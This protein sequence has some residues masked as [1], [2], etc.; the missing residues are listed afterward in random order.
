[1]VSLW[2]RRSLA[3]CAF[4]GMVALALIVTFSRNGWQYEWDWSFDIVGSCTMLLAPFVAGIVAHDRANRIGPFVSAVEI[5]SVR[6]AAA[7]LVLPV[8]A[9]VLACGA[10]LLV[11]LAA[12]VR[13]LFHHPVGTPSLVSPIQVF[14]VL[15]AAALIGAAIGCTLANRAAGPVAAVLVYLAGSFGYLFEVDG[16]FLG[17]RSTGTM[18][19]LEHDPRWTAGLL[20][21]HG[22]LGLAAAAVVYLRARGRSVLVATVPALV[23]ALAA[24]VAFATLSAGAS[25]LRTVSG[26]PQTC[27][28]SAPRVC[29]PP[30][31][32]HLL[33]VAQH[34]LA[35]EY[36]RLSASGL[37]LRDRY[38][39]PRGL[40]SHRFPADTGILNLQP[41][42][43]EGGRYDLDSAVLTLASP[44]YCRDLA[45]EALP[46]R[47]L[48][49]AQALVTRWLSATLHSKETVRPVTPEVRT[50]YDT[51]RDCAPYEGAP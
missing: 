18:V 39:M 1:M 9:I 3:A 21:A 13:V 26:S 41:E 34:G 51:L 33:A 14:V 36:G 22:G 49:D 35:R 48:I 37:D 29:G 7:A 6:A 17:G 5:G 24:L 4:P 32:S 27:L 46:P 31:A 28:G 38:A 11:L 45:G 42:Q 47:D 12:T 19:G 10:W 23:V 30:E 16:L 20:A 25:P 8:A 2:L 15:V 40:P 43:F 50:A 44:T